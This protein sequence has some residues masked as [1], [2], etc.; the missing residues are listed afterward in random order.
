MNDKRENNETLAIFLGMV[1]HEDGWYDVQNALPNYV[2]MIE[3]GNPYEVLRFDQ[4]FDWLIPVVRKFLVIGGSSSYI[5]LANQVEDALV[6]LDIE[7][8]YTALVQGVKHL[9]GQ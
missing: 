6:E 3:R 5:Y 1:R 2:Y 4:S 7:K 8:L 9:E